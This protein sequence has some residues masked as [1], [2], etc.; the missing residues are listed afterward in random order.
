M[1]L[2]KIIKVTMSKGYKLNSGWLSTLKNEK[3]LLVHSRNCNNITCICNVVQRHIRFQQRLK[4]DEQ[5]VHVQD[6]LNCISEFEYFPL[7]PAVPTL[8][9]IQSAIPTSDK[10]ITDLKSAYGDG[11][12]KLMELLKESVFTKSKITFWLYTKNKRLTLAYEKKETSAS[13]KDKVTASTMESVR[14]A[15]IIEIVG[16]SG[17]VNFSEILQYRIAEES[18][19]A[20]NVNCTFRKVKKVSSSKN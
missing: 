8:W 7:D 3:Q 15:E 9:A 19:L 5:V 1:S 17:L 11:E 12:T 20:F 14:L 6:L 13:G 16:K 10:L 18:S 2:D 4:D